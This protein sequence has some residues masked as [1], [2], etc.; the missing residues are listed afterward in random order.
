MVTTS[1]DAPKPL[2]HG[3]RSAILRRPL[4][5]AV[6]GCWVV[7][8]TP[9]VFFPEIMGDAG[10]THASRWRNGAALACLG[11]GAL[12]ALIGAATFAWR[13]WRRQRTGG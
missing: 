3:F 11:L 5:V 7:L 6:G 9:F 1:T 8:L 10:V 12:A 2:R 13:R 4:L